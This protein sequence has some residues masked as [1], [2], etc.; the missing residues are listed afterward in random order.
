MIYT[1]L[2]STHLAEEQLGGVFFEGI[3]SVT[4]PFSKLLVLLSF[5]TC[6]LFSISTEL[7]YGLLKEM[8]HFTVY[9]NVRLPS[10]LL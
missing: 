6:D 9:F 3:V 2:Y 10:T 1:V 4:S 8:P 5:L 7:K